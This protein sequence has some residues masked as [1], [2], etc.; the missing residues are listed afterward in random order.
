M[1]TIS[2]IGVFSQILLLCFLLI[3]MPANASN[4]ENCIKD[5]VIVISS[6]NIHSEMVAAQVLREEVEKRT[7]LK[8]TID[9]AQ[10]SYKNAIFLSSSNRFNSNGLNPE[11]YN[12]KINKKVDG[13]RISVSA[14]D[15]RGVLFGV[16]KFLRMMEW[17][18]GEVG[19]P[20]HM[21]ITSSPQYPIR[22]HQIGYRATANSYDAWT[23]EIYEQY[24]RDLAMFGTNSIEN[25]PLHAGSQ[26]LMKIKP[27]EMNILISQIC[28]KY[29]LDYWAWV[30]AGFDLSDETKRKE[31]ISNQRKFFDE[32]PRLDGVFLPGG[33][34][35][36]NHPKLIMPY[37]AELYK[38][39]IVKHPKAKLWLSLQDF[40]Q[41]EIDYVFDYLKE[42]M[43][44]W[45]GGLVLG[46]GTPPIAEMRE[47]LPEKYQLRDY[48]D[49]THSCRSQ[50][51][52]GWWDSALARTLGRECPN[53]QPLYYSTIHNWSAPYTDGFISYSDGMHDDLNKVLWSAKAWDQ[54]A[55]IRE[56]LKDY[57]RY[58]FRADLAESVADGIFAL[59]DN[60]VGP[61]AQK[62]S[63]ETTLRFWEA[64]DKAAPELDVNWR[65]QLFMVR[66]RYDAYI[67]D[68]VIYERALEEQ[69]NEVLGKASETGADEAMKKSEE[70]LNLAITEPAASDLKAE[71][72]KSAQFLYD[73]MGYQTSMKKYHAV[74]LNRGAIIDYLDMPMNNRLWLEDEFAR[75]SKLSSEEEK[76]K[77]LDIIRNWEN[78]GEGSFYDDLGTLD[79]STHV[80]RGEGL[81]TDPLMER[82]PNPGYWYWDEGFNR[83]RLSWLVSMDEPIAAVYD[84]ID[85]AAEYDVWVTGYR[86]AQIQVNGVWVKP[87]VFSDKKGAVVKYH[88]PPEAVRSG[89]ITL[90][91]GDPELTELWLIKK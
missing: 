56:I 41:E 77:Q 89:K 59:E 52:V 82:N 9:T 40:E 27:S 75:I 83:L 30:P 90:N 80:V 2:G 42:S 53:P 47:R 78:P 70:I 49:I 76:I 68:R 38:L 81:E 11:G 57:G 87:F 54:K 23:P 69:V 79:R 63:V 50:Y 14:M 19:I 62:G 8:W 73:S 10:G 48:P 6:Q 43:P 21:D 71:I 33:D 58:F 91:W 46:P 24:I 34:P 1:K 60:W 22:G 25:I 44:D 29:D 86:V 18:K 88:V 65:W 3:Q 64:L 84:Y 55:D 39:L 7:G 67:R 36:S 28:D 85:S 5:A 37:L 72:E 16:G 61:L 32:T 4:N 51:D 13:Y 74:G 35:G 26:L 45:L 66:A 31:A 20:V 15:A 17:S 12:L